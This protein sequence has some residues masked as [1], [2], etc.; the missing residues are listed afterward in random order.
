MMRIPSPINNNTLNQNPMN[1]NNSNNYLQKKCR[2]KDND[3]LYLKNNGNILNKPSIASN[4]GTF[5]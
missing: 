4:V 2:S 5:I 1:R 3:D